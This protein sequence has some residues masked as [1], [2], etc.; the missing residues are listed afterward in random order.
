MKRILVKIEK[1]NEETID[2]IQVN[3]DK[4]EGKVIP[5]NKAYPMRE[6]PK[7]STQNNCEVGLPSVN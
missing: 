4:E 7:L 6:K 3:K 5:H 2:A 1:L